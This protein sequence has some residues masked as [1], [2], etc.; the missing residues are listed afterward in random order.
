MEQNIRCVLILYN[1]S[2]LHHINI[3]FREPPVLKANKQRA[4]E[5][6]GQFSTGLVLYPQIG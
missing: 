4:V 3:V 5:H 6:P 1:F 2:S